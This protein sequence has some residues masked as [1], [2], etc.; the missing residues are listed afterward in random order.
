[1][2]IALFGSVSRGKKVHISKERDI[3]HKKQL[4]ASYSISTHSQH[5]RAQEM[6]RHNQNYILNSKR[7]L[8]LVIN[9]IPRRQ[10]I[11]E[12]PHP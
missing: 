11:S 10:I 1:M 8:T 6:Q 2:V 3:D 9:Q 7:N 12:T 4:F 5:H